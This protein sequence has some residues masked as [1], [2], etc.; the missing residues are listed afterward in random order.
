MLIGSE[1]S[2]FPRGN[3]W[4]GWRNNCQCRSSYVPEQFQNKGSNYWPEPERGIE[5]PY[6]AILL[7]IAGASLALWEILSLPPSVPGGHSILQHICRLFLP[8]F[9]PFFHLF[10]NL[11]TTYFGENVTPSKMECWWFETFLDGSWLIFT[12]LISPHCLQ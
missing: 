7:Y 9:P 4:T 6:A 1:K 2:C 11:F 10:M 5:S 8:L 3:C 12:H